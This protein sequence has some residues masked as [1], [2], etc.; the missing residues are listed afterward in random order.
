MFISA[1][2]DYEASR[3]RILSG[4]QKV[5]NDFSQN[6]IYPT[7]AELI[8][9][10]QTLQ[11]ITQNSEAIRSEMPKRISGIDLESNSIIYEPLDLNKSE[12]DAIG[13]LINWALP[14]IQQ[15]IEEGKT[16]FN[17][18]D[19][20]LKMEGVGIVPSYVEEGYLLV[21]DI[22]FGVLHVLRY[23]VTIFSG[24]E[25]KYRNLKTT[26]IR[27]LP[28]NAIST[29]AGNVKL[30]LI[31]TNRDLPN[32]ATYLFETDLDFP[33]NETILP[34]AKRKFLRGLYS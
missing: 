30:E 10:F 34:V 22:R 11:R 1:H 24:S 7:L 12:I 23:E 32:P 5:R 18:V 28:L 29:S 14:R 15:A 21:P 19:E 20:H 6:R 31:E 33:F 2:R 25:E 17:F 26:S 16:I 8:E 27:T 3:Y 9:L 4:I 13:D